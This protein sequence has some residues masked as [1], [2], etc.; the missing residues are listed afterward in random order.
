MATI[1]FYHTTGETPASL[2]SILP[3]LLE[4]I[5]ATGQQALIICPTESRAHRLDETLWTYADAA[6]LPHATADARHPEAQPVLLTDIE[7]PTP[8]HAAH[9][10][11]VV[12]A[13]AE[14]ALNTV[15]GAEKIL[16]LFTAAEVDVTRARPLYK[17]L[18]EAGHTLTYWQQTPTGWT[19][20]A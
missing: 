7:H 6:F 16:Y 1:N 3:P 15:T 13:G 17:S 12:L 14:K 10:L 5:L 9:R 18:K 2:D 19:K 8:E 20:K 4:K 11:P